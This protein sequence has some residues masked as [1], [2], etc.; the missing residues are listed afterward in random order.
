MNDNLP[1]E[2]A[3]LNAVRRLLVDDVNKLLEGLSFHVP[4]FEFGNHSGREVAVPGVSLSWCGRTEK[5]RVVFV[6]AYAVE[7][8]VPVEDLREW[9]GE[10][11]MFAY[12]AAIDT[13]ISL[14]KSLGGIVDNVLVTKR[15]YVQPTRRYC[16]D[17]WIL[18]LKLRVTVEGLLSDC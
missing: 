7:V 14:N 10:T 17:C 8:T 11:L 9:D 12:G 6:N 13:A 3:V 5:E 1:M 4:L 2:G 15:D 16:G 18:A